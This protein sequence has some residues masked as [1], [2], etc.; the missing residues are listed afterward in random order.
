MARPNRRPVARSSRRRSLVTRHYTEGGSENPMQSVIARAPASTPTIR[1]MSALGCAIV[2]AALLRVVAQAHG[3]SQ[4]WVATANVCVALLTVPALVAIGA[5]RSQ[6][7]RT[8][9]F[10]WLGVVLAPL[11]SAALLF[12]LAWA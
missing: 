3:Y 2:C 4:P 9:W 11:Q 5:N 12:S 8:Q 1:V 7:A 6:N 10:F